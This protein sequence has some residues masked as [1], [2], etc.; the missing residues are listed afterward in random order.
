MMSTYCLD[1]FDLSSLDRL[2]M[3]I[4]YPDGQGESLSVTNSFELG[5]G[6]FLSFSN[7]FAAH[8]WMVEGAA[9]G[10]FAQAPR[11]RRLPAGWGSSVSTFAPFPALLFPGGSSV[12]GLQVEV[13]D[14]RNRLHVVETTIDV[15]NS[16]ATAI[17]AAIH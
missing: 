5:D 10:A 2:G 12:V 1:R 14:F 8:R 15:D 6:T 17:I 16:K 11:W 13:K 9:E 7:A 4:A 3:S